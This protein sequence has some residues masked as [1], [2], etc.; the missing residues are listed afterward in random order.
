MTGACVLVADAQLLFA[1]ALGLALARHADLEVVPERPRTAP[2]VLQVAELYCPDVAVL[3]LALEGMAPAALV[4]ALARRAPGV[5]VLSIGLLYLP[6]EVDAVLEAGAA[7]FAPKMV[8]LADLT[9]AIRRI[10]AAAAA[11]G[12]LTA[13]TSGGQPAEAQGPTGG[14]PGG[15]PGAGGDHLAD[16]TAR[17]LEVLA[18]LA[19]GLSVEQAADRL[20]VGQSTVRTHIRRILRRTGASSQLEAVALARRHGVVG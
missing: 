2:E 8:P 20:G 5:G 14:A 10:A 4:T 6:Q 11:A 17:Q 18:L 19:R 15:Q 1:D 9:G 12:K 16:L 7:A 3:D 13:T